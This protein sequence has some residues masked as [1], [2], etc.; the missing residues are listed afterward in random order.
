MENIEK[1]IEETIK[2][3]NLIKAEDI[4]NIDLYMD[5]VTTFLTS[6]LTNETSENDEPVFT[7]TMINNYAKSQLLP[8]PEKKKYTKDHMLM[9][10]NIYYLKNIM[11]INNIHKLLDPLSQK[12][13]GQ[14]T[15]FNLST[16]YNEIYKS[17]ET[18]KASTIEDM[19]SKLQLATSSFENSPEED[20]D[21]L[22]LYSYINLL[23]FDVYMKKQLIET[24]INTL[25][26]PADNEASHKDRKDK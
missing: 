8:A 24:L 9:L 3:T 12:F 13:F 16:I 2:N 11:S 15:D 21:Y 5:Q 19:L 18:I 20:S 22:Q 26:A 23:S 17:I 14:K 10:I 4:P 6:H 25:E 1:Y 7:K